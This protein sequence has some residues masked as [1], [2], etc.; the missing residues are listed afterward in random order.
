MHTDII[1]TARVATELPSEGSYFIALV[2]TSFTYDDGYGERGQASTSTARA[3]DVVVIPNEE[4]LKEW[5]LEQDTSKYG[6]PK[7][8]KII[9]AEAVRVIKHVNV[10]LA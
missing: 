7:V 9:K 6:S 8:Y 10:V 3:L 2:E 1:R 5:I 4:V